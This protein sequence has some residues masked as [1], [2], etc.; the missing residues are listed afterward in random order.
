MK[1]EYTTQNNRLKVEIDANTPK[2]V[3]K[4]LAS[5]QEVFAETICG[6]CNSED[7][8][9]QVRTVEGNDYY[10]MRCKSCF[11]KL[12][13]GQ[14]KTGGGLFPKRKIDGEYD[15]ENK[16]WHKWQPKIEMEIKS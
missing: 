4:E 14:N 5:F 13:F 8:K 3:F 9:F 11:A 12:S 1:V 6:A 15:K 10:E 16:G 7:L 2:E